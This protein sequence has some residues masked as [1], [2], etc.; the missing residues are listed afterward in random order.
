MARTNLVVNPS[1]KTNTTGWT[2]L[3]AGTSIARITTRGYY[4]NMCLEITK[5]AVVNAGVRST[6][7]IAVTT[8]Q[9]YALSTYVEVE[10]GQ[11]SGVFNASI[12]WYTALTAGTFI[13]E[14][15]TTTLEA[16]GGGG[17]IR[18]TGVFTAPALAVGAEIR[19]QQTV[20]G[21]AG[22]KVRV[23]AWLLEQS[24]YV[25]AFFNT[26]TQ[27]EKSA[28]VMKALTP[29]PQT[30]IAVTGLNADISLGG[31]VFNT[32]DENGVVWVIT[33][34]EGWWETPEPEMRD[35]PR[36]FGDGSY[37]VHGRYS[38][39]QITLTGVFLPPDSSY[40]AAARSKL[41]EETDL[42]YA[43]AW[44]KTDESPVKASYVRLSG[45]P[46]IKTVNAR[47]RTEFSIGLRAADPLKYEWYEGEEFGYRSVVIPCESASP[48]ATGLGT[49][50]NTGNAYASVTLQVTGPLV[51]PATISNTSTL[52]SVTIL[53]PLR[54]AGSFTVT[55][56]VLTDEVATLTTSTAHDIVAGDVVTVSGVDSTFN[57]AVTVVD[58]TTNT[59]SYIVIAANVTTIA[60]GGT[61]ARDVDVLEL[62]TLNHEVSL[63]G[64]NIGHRNMIDI[65]A[66]WTLVSPGTNLFSFSDSGDPNS[67]ASLAIY[68][69]SAWLG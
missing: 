32:I 22:T 15:A 62:D 14:S 38:A 69:R 21:T 49:L 12:H 44:L 56:K 50:T 51:G 25:G 33:D 46:N 66:D 42:V 34:I 3:G 60:S 11:E 43:G 40:V 1:Y 19:L 4:G 63:N 5:G 27:A 6:D 37:D 2:A 20:A 8:G 13:S 47:G 67:T 52:E 55:N 18:L 48:V 36:G 57:G 59:F 16:I 29:E 24:E 68:Y 64:N 17:F 65:L 28:V 9:S 31:L 58:S 26:V 30:L 54:A 53:D 23:D 61:V 7:R 39:R 35:I 45:R 10:A 41:I